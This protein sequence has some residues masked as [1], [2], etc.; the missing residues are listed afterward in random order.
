[1]EI[2]NIKCSSNKHQTN[3]I[4][5]CD[6]CKIYMCN[7]CVNLHSDLFGSHQEIKLSKDM[8]NIFTG[9]CK[10]ATHRNKLN[11]FCKS[12][13]VLCC[14][15]CICKIKSEG[16]GS[17]QNCEIFN[18]EDIKDEKKNNLKENIKYL[19]DLSK[20][21][22]N[23]I[24]ELKTISEEINKKKEDLKLKI[25]KIFSQ[26]RNALNE[27]EDQILSEVDNKFNDDYFNEDLIKRSDKI[28]N[29]IKISLEKGKLIENNWDDNNKLNSL[30]N[31]CLNIENNI[32]DIKTINDS[33]KKYNV[34]DKFPIF[35]PKE[36]EINKLLELIKT[37]GKLEKE[38][39]VLGK[40]LKENDLELLSNWI[41][42]DNPQINEVI[43]KLCYDAKKNGDDKNAFHKY[44]L[45]AGPTLLVVKT[46]SNYIFGGY[47]KENWEIRNNNNMYKKDNTAFLFSLNNK[48][49]IKVKN[50][51]RAI[52]NDN[53][54]GPVFGHGNAYEICLFFPFL[55]QNIQITEG[56]DY[57][58]KTSVL[59][60]NQSKK[61]IEIEMYK[62]SF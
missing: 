58:D 3:A 47:T 39:H 48:E 16:N 23:S 10:E 42:S 51:D 31:D 13:N 30:I 21:V 40:L 8:N 27:R 1:M 41:K 11:Y 19:E 33:I 28:P 14:A 50:S 2:D 46:E 25:L 36:K 49:R 29:K 60:G 38:N 7:K 43:F 37:F 35:N 44:C 57:G 5:Y 9:F 61:P 26:I 4:S 52:V 15:N 56:G 59:V 22:D 12:H 34:N 62:V 24:K 17:H 20:T 45:N 55:S 32:K 54:Y 6:I 53:S 18:L